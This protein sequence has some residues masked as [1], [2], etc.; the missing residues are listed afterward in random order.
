M[1]SVFM[2]TGGG[3]VA[4]ALTG[5]GLVAAQGGAFVETQR[6]IGVST[7]GNILVLPNIRT[8]DHFGTTLAVD[9]DIAVV[10]VPDDDVFLTTGDTL[11][12]GWRSGA[13]YVFTRNRARG[14]WQELQKLFPSDAETA[15]K[16]G[17]TVAV[18]GDRI[19]IGDPA[20]RVHTERAGAAFLFERDPASGSWQQ[21]QILTASDAKQFDSFGSAVALHGDTILVGSLNS[22]S[23]Q[24]GA[25]FFELGAAGIWRQRQKV[26]FPVYTFGSSVAI[27]GAMAIVGAPGDG[28]N[29]RDT[30]SV[31]VYSRDPNT[32]R[33]ELA[34]RLFALDVGRVGRANLD[35]SGVE[36]VVT[37]LTGPR[38]VAL[39]PVNGKVYWTSPALGKIQRAN[40][41]GTGAEDVVTR[42][43]YV[44]EGI[45]LDASASKVY[46]TASFLGQIERT[47]KIARANL[48]GGSVEELVN[49][50]LFPPK[51]IAIDAAG[52]KMYW[53]DPASSIRR[54]NLD[55]T[56][57]EFVGG[58][59]AEW[60]A[61]DLAAA[62]MY[63]TDFSGI[64]RANL[65]GSGAE[66]LVFE[67]FFPEGI[68]LDQANGFV[69]WA[70]PQL[71]AIRRARLNGTGVETVISGLNGPIGV[72]IDSFANKVYWTTAG[73]REF[74]GFGSSLAI[75]DGTLVVGV[76]GFLRQG[77]AHVF[78]FN[79]VAGRW[80]GRQRL[81]GAGP[82]GIDGDAFGAALDLDGDALAVGAPA[83]RAKGFLAGAAYLFRRNSLTGL[84][85]GRERLIASDGTAEDSFG[86]S[87]GVQ[88]DQ[89]LT[90]AAGRDFAPS[91]PEAGLVYVF[92]PSAAAGAATSGSPSAAVGADGAPPTA[93]LFSP[94]STLTLGTMLKVLRP[95]GAGQHQF[96]LTQCDDVTFST[97]FNRLDSLG[98]P[99]G[100]L[101]GKTFSTT[102]LTGP[103]F[104]G[105]PSLSIVRRIEPGDADLRRVEFLH[106]VPC[107]A[108]LGRTAFAA[109]QAITGFAAR[110]NTNAS[111]SWITPFDPDSGGSDSGVAR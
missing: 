42:G 12:V 21:V 37:G 89:L 73:T 61:L 2:L 35:G 90:G 36:T 88:G 65:D 53:T 33:W 108:R 109:V 68:A 93:P 58:V 79:A 100:S 71:G 72:A 85:G 92:G 24:G 78:R 18:D 75:E 57:I 1:R 81:T 110:G 46:W 51:G 49:T 104:D 10:G 77:S 62:K 26:E 11:R 91:V 70:V 55:G 94:E 13:A 48:D 31:F 39:D 4:V 95:G 38:G 80:E 27:E 28:T 22:S 6:L 84:W 25:Y 15:G 56:S 83:D 103:W 32:R 14:R 8:G 47:G 111:V 69:Y 63:W 50:Q 107:S 106:A 60:I 96:L 20:S 30:G 3:I 44:P 54:A 67:T 41:D 43:F 101:V 34:Q 19:L 17:T 29:G 5:L 40:L 105:S 64:Q 98:A 45:A 59:G 87:V 74:D 82:P 52:G 102:L 76:P 66:D 86:A 99:F 9:D 7:G 97:A 16:F 23:S